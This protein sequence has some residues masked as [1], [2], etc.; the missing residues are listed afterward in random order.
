METEES[1]PFYKHQHRVV[2]ANCGRINPEDIREA[3]AMG[4]YAAIARVLDEMTPEQV[5][6][7]INESGLRGRG[8]A[9]FPTGRKWQFAKAAK[10]DKST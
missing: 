3:I 5:I 10:S 1:I 8:G 7:L 9:G 2:L 6:E 4:G